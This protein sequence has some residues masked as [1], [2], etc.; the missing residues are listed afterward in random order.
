[1]SMDRIIREEARLI[2]LRALAEQDDEQLNSELLRVT[3]ETFGISRMR[4]W[5]HGELAYLAEMGAVTVTEAGSVRVAQLTEL[6]ARHLARNVAIE[7]VKR[8]SRPEA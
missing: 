1:M 7:G 2:I 8:P 3:L 6:G 5:V 4:A